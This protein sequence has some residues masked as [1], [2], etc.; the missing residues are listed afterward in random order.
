MAQRSEWRK[1]TRPLS[2]RSHTQAQ[3]RSSCLV[4]WCYLPSQNE[5]KLAP[6]SRKFLRPPSG[7]KAE[8]S[9][10]KLGLEFRENFPMAAGISGPLSSEP[11]AGLKE[12]AG[13]E[14]SRYKGR[15]GYM[16]GARRM[17]RPGRRQLEQKREGEEMEGV[18]SPD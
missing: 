3:S 4:T 17:S 13:W 7:N 15:G 1:V 16:G 8:P 11:G 9:D 18:G 5:L 2:S 6:D 10:K 12:P 14:G